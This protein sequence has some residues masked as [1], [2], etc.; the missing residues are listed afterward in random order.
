MYSEDKL[1]KFNGWHDIW[2]WLEY[3]P[4]V[5]F[6]NKDAFYSLNDW[7]DIWIKVDT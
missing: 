6:C 3:K 7:T 5:N 4:E 1:I 2:S